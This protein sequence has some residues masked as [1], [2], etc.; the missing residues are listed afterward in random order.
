[1]IKATDLR[2]GNKLEYFINE[3]GIEWDETTVDAQDILWCQDKEETFNK[4]HRAIK[5]TEERLIKLGFERVV[6]EFPNMTIVRYNAPKRTFFLTEQFGFQ[7][8]LY[9]D[10]EEEITIQVDEV[11]VLQNVYHAVTGREL[12]ILA[13]V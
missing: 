4:V 1:M 6:L 8:L 7:L 9:N 3:E 12:E 13:P 5:L 11:H 2:V 10:R